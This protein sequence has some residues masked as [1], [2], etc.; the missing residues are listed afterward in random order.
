MPHVKKSFNGKPLYIQRF[1]H[2]GRPQCLYYLPKDPPITF[3]S[4]L[5]F[6][7]LPKQVGLDSGEQQAYSIILCNNILGV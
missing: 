4:I 1:N 6:S 2:Y 7:F 3:P 5:L